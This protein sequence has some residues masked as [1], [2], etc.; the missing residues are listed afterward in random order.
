MPFEF[1]NPSG[2]EWHKKQRPETEARNVVEELRAEI[3][4]RRKTEP[5]VIVQRVI[6]KVVSESEALVLA[7][8]GWEVVTDVDD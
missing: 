6:R 8:N 4:E 2:K 7:R 1:P 3:E 5:L